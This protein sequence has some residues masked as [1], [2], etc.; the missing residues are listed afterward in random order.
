MSRLSYYF[1]STEHHHHHHHFCRSLRGDQGLCKNKVIQM[2]IV[3]LVLVMAFCLIAMATLY[4]L[5]WHK[6]NSGSDNTITSTDN[7]TSQSKPVAKNQGQN[8]TGPDNSNIV[9]WFCTRKNC[10]LKKFCCTVVIITKPPSLLHGNSSKSRKMLGGPQIHPCLKPP[11]QTF[12]CQNPS[13]LYTVDHD[14]NKTDKKQPQQI[15]YITQISAPP[16]IGQSKLSFVCASKYFFLLEEK[17]VKSN[18]VNNFAHETFEVQ[19]MDENIQQTNRARS[20]NRKKHC[21][22][23]ML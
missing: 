11:C 9:T 15:Y 10:S 19:T 14:G 3:I 17:T 7:K 23:I 2:T 18:F 12:C 8:P 16:P 21:N 22:L 6:R 13:L 5:D 4:V 20:F 1:Y